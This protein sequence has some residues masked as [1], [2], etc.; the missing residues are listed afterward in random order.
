MWDGLLHP[1]SIRHLPPGH[2][3]TDRL[4]ELVHCGIAM[5]LDGKAL[6]E[7]VC[8]HPLVAAVDRDGI[9]NLTTVESTMRN[10][11]M[12]SV[13]LRVQHEHLYVR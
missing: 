12:S 13:A 10:Q 1:V 4:L 8:V 3:L 9:E 2:L 11:A 5:D 7:A 6:A